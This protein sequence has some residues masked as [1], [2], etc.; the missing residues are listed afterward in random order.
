MINLNEEIDLVLEGSLQEIDIKDLSSDTSGEEQEGTAIGYLQG[1]DKGL[2]KE[3]TGL[4]RLAS[5][6]RVARGSPVYITNILSDEDFFPDITIK[7]PEKKI[8]QKFLGHDGTEYK[9]PEDVVGR[10]QRRHRGH[11]PIKEWAQKR[12][13]DSLAYIKGEGTIEVDGKEHT[14]NFKERASTFWDSKE[15]KF[16]EKLEEYTNDLISDLERM[17]PEP[18]SPLTEANPS[19]IGKDRTL[20]DLYVKITSFLQKEGIEVDRVISKTLDLHKEKIEKSL[21]NYVEKNKQGPDTRSAVYGYNGPNKDGA[22]KSIWE[23]FIKHLKELRS[24]RRAAGRAYRSYQRRPDP[25][26]EPEPETEPWTTTAAA[27]D[28]PPVPSRDH[29]ASTDVSISPEIDDDSTARR[30]RRP[31][32]RRRIGFQQEGLTTRNRLKM[33]KEDKLATIT[34]DFNEL[35]KQELNESFLAMFGG[36]VE[37]ILGAMFGGR[38]LPLAVKG[39]QRDVESFAKTLGG[40]K[41]YLEA[42]K[43]YGLDHPTTYK[44]KSKLDNAVKGFEKETGLKWPFK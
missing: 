17:L 23:N 31:T 44:N 32:A 15:D 16:R 21:K 43:R 40:E 3:F 10:G 5:I 27:T 26:P 11:N 2:I 38:S 25:E 1:L 20:H 18:E 42:V 34:I 22:T 6:Y 12:L 13:A 4:V 7:L 8:L 33:L 30:R 36:W 29:V 28:L 24:I 14:L 37:H 9:I 35:R 39:S 41:S 19:E